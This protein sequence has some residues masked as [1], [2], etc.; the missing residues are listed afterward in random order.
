MERGLK[1]LRDEVTEFDLDT[2]ARPIIIN[3]DPD[4]TLTD[5]PPGI[6]HVLEDPESPLDQDLTLTDP[7]ATPTNPCQNL[8]KELK[9]VI[10]EDNDALENSST[11]FCPVVEKTTSDTGIQTEMSGVEIETKTSKMTLSGD[12]SCLS[13]CATS[14]GTGPEQTP[15]NTDSSK[16]PSFIRLDME[17]SNVKKIKEKRRRRR[18]RSPASNIHDLPKNT[19]NSK[20]NHLEVASTESGGSSCDPHEEP[21]FDLELSGD[22]TDQALLM[23]SMGRAVSMPLIEDKHARTD[24]WASSQYAAALH[25]FSDGDITPLVRYAGKMVEIYFR[26]YLVCTSGTKYVLYSFAVKYWLNSQI[27]NL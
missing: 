25:P 7:D 8:L 1:E 11:H 23:T 10:D 9:I 4:P 6:A 21:L 12:D 26:L 5:A 16:L 13:S 18:K 3:I 2:G 19:S 22:E 24:E 20:N 15:Q 14:T 17:T 27:S